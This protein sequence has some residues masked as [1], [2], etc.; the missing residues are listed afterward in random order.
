[1]LNIVGIQNIFVK[2]HCGHPLIVLH[3]FTGVE[4]ACAWV[5]IPTQLQWLLSSPMSSSQIFLPTHQALPALIE[6]WLLLVIFIKDEIF[7]SNCQ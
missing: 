4:Q 5:S 2:K 7:Y 3:F 6:G 1:M